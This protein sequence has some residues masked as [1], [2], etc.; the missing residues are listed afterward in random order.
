MYEHVL[1]KK[2]RKKMESHFQ[3]KLKKRTKRNA[4]WLVNLVWAG[5][6]GVT[7]LST[8]IGMAITSLDYF[9]FYDVIWRLQLS[10]NGGR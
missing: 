7:V 1:K 10:E 3:K 9:S 5:K 2:K 6:F 8:S 4:I